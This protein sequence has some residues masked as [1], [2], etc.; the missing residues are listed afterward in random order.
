M[1]DHK[2]QL[3]P[4]HACTH[5]EWNHKKQAVVCWFPLSPI[6]RLR[7]ADMARCEYFE[8]EPGADG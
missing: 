4:C 5:S 1:S 3:P 2:E 7:I 8:R 6:F